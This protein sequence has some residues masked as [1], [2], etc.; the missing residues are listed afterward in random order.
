MIR[1]YILLDLG[2]GEEG[3]KE[4]FA[5]ALPSNP[6][7]Y[8]YGFTGGASA[9]NG[10]LSRGVRGQVFAPAGTLGATAGGP[11][12]R[13]KRKSMRVLLLHPEDPIP[14]E[15]SGGKWDLVVDLG[16]APLATYERWS[17]QTGG[18]VISVYDFARDFEDLHRVRELLQLGIG[19]WVDG[20]GIDWWDVLSLLI[21]PD[22]RQLI[23]IGRLA[24][25][26]KAGCELYAS[27]S[28]AAATA[29]QTFT[30][31]KQVRLEAGFRPIMRWAQHYRDVF[32]QLDPAQI[33]QACSGQIRS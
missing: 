30:G 28:S 25:E 19:R 1:K 24:R 31:A 14:G 29:L 4:R 9:G 10:A 15:R 32:A 7:R 20:L 17:A 5:S 13:G 16:R 6:A 27:R 12:F 26:L 11:A 3:Y 2:L 8:N 23:L 33:S 22:L 21:E 18:R